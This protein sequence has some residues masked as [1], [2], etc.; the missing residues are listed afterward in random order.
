[1]PWQV[2][3]TYQLSDEQ[4]SAIW[5]F[6]QRKLVLSPEN[7]AAVKFSSGAH[8]TNAS[9]AIDRSEEPIAKQVISLPQPAP[10]EE[11]ERAPVVAVVPDI[12]P[13]SAIEELTRASISEFQAPESDDAQA[14]DRDEAPLT[15]TADLLEALR[16]KRAEAQRSETTK[17]VPEAQ[18]AEPNLASVDEL[19]PVEEIPPV[20]EVAPNPVTPAKKGRPSMPS[21][22]EI[23]FGTKTDD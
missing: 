10:V 15:A 14:P 23:V 21:W 13:V 19:V 2:T 22:D 9:T 7:E 17:S 6:D 1:M 18:S 16:K 3:V 5:S 4:I 12:A 8:G 11:P 20:E